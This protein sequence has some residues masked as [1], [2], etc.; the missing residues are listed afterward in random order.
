MADRLFR[1][2]LRLLP[3]EFRAGYGI[4]MEAAF[5]AERRE[6]RAARRWGALARLWFATAADIVR[7]APREHLAVLRRDLTFAL[8]LMR[9]RISHT[10]AAV[11]TLAIGIGANVAMFAVVDAVLL[12]PLPYAEPGRLV[13]V[14]ETEAGADPSNVGYLTYVDLSNRTR[15]FEVMSAASASTATL[16]GGDRDPERVTAMRVSRMYFDM[17]GV[18]PAM[19]RTFTETEDRPGPARRVVVLA[20][21]LWRRRFAA[22]PGIV[23]RPIEIAGTSYVVVGV[24][25]ASF[26]DLIAQ[27]MYNGTE[28]WTPLGYDPAASFACRTCRHLRVFGR[29]RADV[30]AAEAEAE[31]DAIFKALEADTPQEYHEAGARVTP[32]ADVFLGP[33]RPVLLVLWGG[34]IVLLL[35]ANGNVANLL[36]LR[37]SERAHEIAV[38]AALGVTRRRLGRQLVTEALLLSA[39]GGAA[40][41]VLAAFAVGALRSSGLTELPRLAEAALDLR[42]LLVATGLSAVSGV[43]F[44]LVPLRHLMRRAVSPWALGGREPAAPSAVW[45]ARSALVA[46]NVAMATVLLVGSAL[47]VRS[48]MGL[49]AI[50]PGLDPAGVMT[51]QVWASGER[52]RAGSTEDQIATATAFYDEVL[53]RLGAVPG[54]T[55]AAAVTTLPFGGGVDAYGLH[56]AG[57]LEANPEAAPSAD[58]F[59]VAGDVFGTL[60]IPLRRGR[61]LDAGDRQGSEAVAVINETMARELFAGEDPLGHRI[62]LGS[63]A[64]DPRVI[65]GV[66]GDVRHHGFDVPVGYQ[67]YV[68]QA[69]WAWAETFMTLV[70]RSQGDG[71]RIVPAARDILRGIDPAQ[72]LTGARLYTDILAATIGTR[73]FAAQLLAAFAATALVLSIVG[74]YGALSVAVGQRRREIGIRAALG[75]PAASLGRLVLGQGLRPVLVG[76]T[77]GLVTAGLATSSLR[78]LLYDV[79]TAD[80][81]SFGAAA[82]VVTACAVAACLPPARRATRIRPAETLRAE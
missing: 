16:T 57:R 44:G 30:S 17:L 56:I 53:G 49:V 80:P 48:L 77:V 9:A 21:S 73:R 7:H 64:A 31:L 32:L 42:A 36:L 55:G 76:L 10:I 59:V 4:D 52:F 1:L 78:A 68:P 5:R 23:G 22:D 29:L 11:L 18:R 33:V 8:R 38:R 13:T 14:A 82:F 47:L 51:M 69:Q 60:R 67:V 28:L 3:E 40:G 45:R 66:V 19:G 79:G 63:P 71:A 65:V 15:L 2:L 37:S 39:A 54:V 74:L 72:P 58:R 81:A 75:A 20:D 34:V 27:R 61:V 41:V 46:A 6:A 25:P 50:S 43:A 26:D 12:T 35:V 62:H 24:L 70:V